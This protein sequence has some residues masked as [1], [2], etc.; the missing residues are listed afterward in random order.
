MAAGTESKMEAMAEVMVTV[1]EKEEEVVGQGRE[2]SDRAVRRVG[3][4]VVG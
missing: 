2:V 4:H 1:A 3:K